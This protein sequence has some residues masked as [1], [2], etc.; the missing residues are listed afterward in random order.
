MEPDMKKN[1]IP[2]KKRMGRPSMGSVAKN[3][4]LTVR[5]SQ[6]EITLWT[7]LAAKE[8]LTLRQ[9]IMRPVRNETEGK[10]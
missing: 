2:Q 10:S 3:I 8:G 9:F 4:V 6:D 7:K 5:I 1:L